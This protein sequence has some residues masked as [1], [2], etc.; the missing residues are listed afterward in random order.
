MNRAVV[1]LLCMFFALSCNTERKK[2]TNT[3]AGLCC[4]SLSILTENMQQE[5]DSL[6]SLVLYQEKKIKELIVDTQSLS[7]QP[8]KVKVMQGQFTSIGRNKCFSLVFTDTSGTEWDFGSANNNLGINL[9]SYDYTSDQFYFNKE[10]KEA[11][12]RLY[13]A[14]L[15][16]IVCEDGSEMPDK[17]QEYKEMPTILKAE[18]IR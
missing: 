17:N 11:E 18:R 3:E 14:M 6:L 13:W 16:N 1:F 4:D 5:I 7:Y 15:R 12:F 10:Y 9:Y 2:K 8:L